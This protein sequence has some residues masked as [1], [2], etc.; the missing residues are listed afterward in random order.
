LQKY[1]EDSQVKSWIQLSISPA[2]ASVL[3][4]LKSDRSLHLYIDYWG[5][6]KITKKDWYLLLLVDEI[7]DQLVG[8]LYFIKIDLQDTY[9]HI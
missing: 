1:L 7:L 4:I 2:E 5:L 9:H 6:N 8:F 3:F